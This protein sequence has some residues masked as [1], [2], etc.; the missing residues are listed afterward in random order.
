MSDWISVEDRLPEEGPVLVRWVGEFFGHE[1][2]RT[3]VGYYDDPADYDDPD[4]GQGW[5]FWRHEQE[6]KV[7]HWMPLPEPPRTEQ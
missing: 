1:D 3:D 5:L 6:I 4:D 2:P 7:T